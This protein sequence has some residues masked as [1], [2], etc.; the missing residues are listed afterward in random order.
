MSADNWTECPKCKEKALE[1]KRL[2][3]M[4]AEKQY[5]KVSSIRYLELI[6][7]AN[8]IN[9][10]T[11]N[12]LREDYEIGICKDIFEINYRA[13]CSCGF[14]FEFKEEKLIKN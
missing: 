10:D 3:I 4:D 11:D 2:A 8:K 14:S 9:T 1:H 13:S 7:R 5:G 12:S 6:E